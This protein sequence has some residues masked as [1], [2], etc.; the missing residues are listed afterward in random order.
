MNDLILLIATHYI[1]AVLLIVVVL[2]FLAFLKKQSYKKEIQ[3]L[4]KEKNIIID[5]ALMT[6]LSKVESLAKN[7]KMKI[8]FKTWQTSV[9]DIKNDLLENITDFIL[10][11]DFLIDQKDF[12]GF[13]LKKIKA[14][15][16]IYEAREKRNKLFNQIQEITLSETKSRDSITSLKSKFREIRKTFDLS[17][18]DF[19]ELAETVKLQIENIEKRFQDFEIKMENQDY[20]EV[21][22]IV[23]SLDSMIKHMD[24]IIEELPS[25]ILMVDSLI[26]KR[27]EEVELNYNKLT[28][29]G[30][31]LD[32]LNIEYNIEE[33]RKKIADIMS[34]V[35]VLNLEDVL[36]ELKTI[37]EYFDSI[38]NDFERERLAKKSFEE[39]IIAFKSKINK[40]NDVMNRLYG[41]VVDAKYN[42]TL[43]ED[44]L[45]VLKTLTDEL[46]LINKDFDILYDTTKT[47]SFPYS[48]LIKE[49]EVLMIRLSKT[50]EK[51]DKYM[52]TIGNMQDDEKRAREQLNE[53]TELLKTSK[54]KIREYKLPIIPN[55]YFVELKEAGEG[56]REII[57]ELDRK[58]IDI[59]TLNTRVDTARD[60]VFKFYNTT[61][62]IIK[63]AIMAENAIIY[64]N[65]YRSNKS[66]IDEGLYK[67][68]IL[69]IKGDYKKSLELTLNTI[70]I[71]EPGIHK[72]LLSLYEKEPNI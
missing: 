46:E 72:K 31:Q 54:Y 34:R 3:N 47:V 37:L 22:R 53:I 49:L 23:K 36:F 32:Y 1:L 6:E 57:K 65:R 52:Q 28:T 10:D 69:F 64:G 58:P 16:K 11:A 45:E 60:L 8:K 41:K 24:V 66:Y 38:F 5:P 55:N 42:Y 51:L 20:D 63:T 56:I 50:E 13:H 7:D 17:T 59:E 33:I 26:P 2:N 19:G 61:N 62:E 29:E 71:I 15:L 21:N 9:N 39:D 67:S 68:E 70:D 4:D 30:Y 14:E 25:A 35:R 44:Q 40:I 43:S 18:S 48:R 12:K 27:I